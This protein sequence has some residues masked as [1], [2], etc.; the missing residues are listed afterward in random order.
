MSKKKLI[1]PTDALNA[2]RERWAKWRKTNR[3]SDTKAE[4]IEVIRVRAIAEALEGLRWKEQPARQDPSALALAVCDDRWDLIKKAASLIERDWLPRDDPRRFADDAKW[5]AFCLASIRSPKLGKGD[6]L[7]YIETVHPELF[8]TIRRTDKAR[9]S[10]WAEIGGEQV[11]DAVSPEWKRQFLEL[12]ATAK[13][14][15]KAGFPD[16]LGPRDNPTWD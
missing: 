7:H 3:P 4:P 16:Y 12:I 15:K 8:A 13:R 2:E 14:N 5:L 6:I 11:R 10:W 1:C 9:T